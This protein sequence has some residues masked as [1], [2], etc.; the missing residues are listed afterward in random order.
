MRQNVPLRMEWSCL[1]RVLSALVL[2]TLVL[3]TAIPIQAKAFF[4]PVTIKG[5]VVGN[6]NKPLQNVS[7]SV[8]GTSAGTLT[9]ADGT[10]SISAP[11]RVRALVFSLVGYSTLQ[12]IVENETEINVV[13]QQ[14]TRALEEVTVTGYTAYNR[15]Q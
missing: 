2:L 11:D 7:V 1:R 3:I 8:A 4:P 10:F 13:L 6:D 15:S 9:D 5:K 12:V 14:S